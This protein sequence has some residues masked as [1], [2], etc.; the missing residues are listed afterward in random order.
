MLFLNAV[1]PINLGKQVSWGQQL[2]SIPVIKQRQMSNYNSAHPRE[3]KIRRGGTFAGKHSSASSMKKSASTPAHAFFK[4]EKRSI[5]TLFLMIVNRPC[6]CK[7]E[8][9]LASNSELSYNE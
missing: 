8:V 5:T 1:F 4:G 3:L 2:H 9:C 7:G 6:H